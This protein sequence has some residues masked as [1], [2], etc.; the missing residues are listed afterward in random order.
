ML[1][2]AA[3]AAIVMSQVHFCLG[4]CSE[5][6]KTLESYRQRVSVA[7][8]MEWAP[9]TPGTPGPSTSASPGVAQLLRHE[10]VDTGKR[11]R[12]ALP[13]AATALERKQAGGLRG[14]CNLDL[15]CP[16]FKKDGAKAVSRPDLCGR[17][18]LGWE[19]SPQLWC[20]ACD[21]GR[22]AYFHLPCFFQCH[23]CTHS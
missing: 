23:T 22:G 8:Q 11:A 13:Y 18:A 12:E 6:I 5:R 16:P 2:I 19:D 7:T 4:W 20:A 21:D 15:G 3:I 9:L 17:R 1:L 10:L 14:Q